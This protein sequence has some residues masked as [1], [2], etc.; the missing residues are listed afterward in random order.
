M[1]WLVDRRA[2][3]A[4]IYSLAQRPPQKMFGGESMFEEAISYFLVALGTCGFVAAFK[5]LWDTIKER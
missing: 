2:F 4:S 1:A 5:L 3:G